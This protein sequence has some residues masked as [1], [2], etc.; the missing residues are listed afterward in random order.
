MAEFWGKVGGILA[1][2]LLTSVDSGTVVGQLWPIF[3]DIVNLWLSFG[4]FLVLVWLTFGIWA[5][6]GP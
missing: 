5:N 4:P 6:I 2:V 3:G 1:L